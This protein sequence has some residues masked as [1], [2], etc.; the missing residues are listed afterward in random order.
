MAFSFMTGNILGDAPL[1][2]NTEKPTVKLFS[3]NFWIFLEKLKG[4]LVDL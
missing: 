2:D 3:F 1:N 4:D